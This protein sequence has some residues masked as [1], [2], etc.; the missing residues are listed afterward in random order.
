MYSFKQLPAF[1]RF[2]L[3]NHLADFAAEQVSLSRSMKLPIML[4]LSGRFT[5]EQI[6]DIAIKSSTEYLGFIEE[7]KGLE[8]IKES[9]AKWM[10]DQLEIVAK[11]DIAAPDIT[12]LN[13]IRG[14]AFKK[15]IPFFTTVLETALLI[16]SEIDLLL[17]GSTT[18]STSIYIEILRNKIAEQS[19]LA[20]KVIEASPAI[21]FLFDTLKNKQIFISGKVLQ[22]LGYTPEELMQMNNNM[23]IQ[24]IHPHDLESLIEHFQNFLSLNSNET[25]KV[26][27]R[28]RHKDG[29]YQW[30]RTYEVIFSRDNNGSPLMILGKTFEI[31]SE[32][33]T[34]MALQKRER[35]LLEAQSI[36]Q[37]GSYE[38]NIRENK[39]TNT[40]QVFRIF[41]MQDQQKYE[42][43]MSYVHPDDIQ[44]VKDAIA[45]SFI[46]GIY[47]CE[48]RYIKNNREK[49]IWSLGKVE[50]KDEEPIRMV[51]TVQDV[52]EIKRMEKALVQRTNELAQSNDSLR[53]FAFVASHDMKEPLRKIMMFSD[54][55]LSTEK[56]N[57]SER[58]VY[59]LQK[60]QAAGKNLY[61]MVED[62]LSFSLLQSKEV[63]HKVR[64]GSIVEQVTEI[65]EENI[66]EKNATIVCKDLPEATIIESQF[67]QLFQNLIVNSLK[68][69]K[70][71]EPPRIVIDA[72]VV[73]NPNIDLPVKADRFLEINVADNGIG[74]QEGVKEK[75]FELFSRVHSKSEYEGTGLGLSISRRIVEN[76]E[77]A[78]V[79]NSKPGAGSVFTI[80]I[81]Q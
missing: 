34:A 57:L 49:V 55:V 21:T 56:S 3:N 16:N 23:L 10:Q 51:G 35:Q 44:K 32:K 53:Q 12:L 42:E 14:Q 7:N 59:H 79:A 67:R 61:H 22:V 50:F 43:F 29:K 78:I 36:A 39:S 19:K 11:G 24:L 5:D 65:L 17:L 37:I 68:F 70:K 41:E 13:Y 8:Q 74:F 33:E 76:H 31:T 75:I 6:T 20:S 18:T 71:D 58:S 25:G 63:K 77:G 47:E 80:L 15:F 54:L 81:P 9:M 73:T 1:A 72:R 28:F 60:M 62:I 26:E 52:T 40:E 69:S 30:L 2:I 38:W 66:K 64:L 4:S 27:C 46:N 45:Q 48:Y